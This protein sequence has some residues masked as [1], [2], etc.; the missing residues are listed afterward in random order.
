MTSRSYL[1]Y[2]SLLAF[3]MPGFN[4]CFSQTTKVTGI[5]TD[6]ETGETLPGVNIFFKGTKIGTTTNIDG[7]FSIESYYASDSLVASF[8]GYTPLVMP[9]KKD[10]AQV[11]HFALKPAEETLSEVV[12]VAP[13]EDPAIAIFKNIIRNKDANNREKL[14]SYQYEVYNK[15]EFDLNNFDEK[16]MNRKVFQPI[17]F[18]FENVDSAS[19]KPYLPVFMT[20]SVSDF[21]YRK[22]PK[23]HK[24]FI[25]ATRV[26]GVEN[27]SVSQFLGDMY[28]NINIYDNFLSIFGKSFVSPISDRGM[29]YYEYY[30]LDSAFLGDNWCYKIRFKPKRIQ[31]PTFIGNFWVND[32]SYA[33]RKI[34]AGIAEDA[35]I[36]FITYFEFIQEFKEVENEVWMLNKDY[37]L[38][39]FK[40]AEKELGFFG[41]K[42][43]S[44]ENHIVN[45]P[46]DDE[47]YSGPNN[48]IVEADADSRPPEYWAAARHDSL[49][50][51]E[52]AIYQMMDT[53]QDIPQVKNFVEV[54]SMLISGYK[55]MGKVEWGPY[56]STFSFNTFE[57]PRFRLGGRTS[58][59]FSKRFELN[60]YVAYGT[61]DE[62]FKYGA[63]F[64][65]M[66]TKH[67]RQL[68]QFNYIYDLEQLGISSNSFRTDNFLAAVFRRNPANKLSMVEEYRGHY[69]YEYF[70]GL[71]NRL[72][73]RRRTISP[74]G[75]NPYY[76]KLLTTGEYMP[77]PDVTTTELTYYVRFAKDEKFVSGEFDRVSLGTKKPE[78]DLHYSIGIKDFLDS[79]Y[80]YHKAVVSMTQW[81]PVGIYGWFRY[82]VEAGKFWGT[83]PYP[84]LEL[85]RG[86]ETYYYD[87]TAFNTMN[88]VEFVSDQYAAVFLT[89][90]F[91]G[92]FL[93]H[94]PLLR[95]LKWREVIGVKAVWGTISEA[96]IQEFRF[97]EYL[98]T[99]TYPFV[100][101]SV[102]IEN[103]L[104]VLRVDFIWR[105]SYLD[106]PDITKFGIRAKFDVDF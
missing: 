41:R 24:E 78:I 46:K 71:M 4:L 106:H 67:P 81:V 3:I 13:E 44:Y 60:G 49:T 9:V 92:L 56:F 104:K 94:I 1:L 34:E 98:H 68:I 11:I 97:P 63:G 33:I 51:N 88:Y 95:R 19:G 61:K 84:V 17:S 58:N 65:Y 69:E 55:V 87:E 27:N 10:R 5:V 12:V 59:A 72:Q 30:L 76:E 105:M 86:N 37:L 89:H 53:I 83:L 50:E 47:F 45:E 8:I 21:Y 26:S 28:Q 62:K 29:I 66:I 36:N 38:V 79:D 14:E 16:F 70:Q 40:I 35:N 57:G 73:F 7:D 48:I 90:H 23:T 31:E 103:I 6:A 42:T 91:D 52:K 77:V 93:N 101:G 20:E 2:I 74:L 18:I 96:N 54:V 80:G 99:L 15:V 102:G 43:T 82:R 32:T 64:R 39:D 22:N 85:H 25:K 75:E 100:E